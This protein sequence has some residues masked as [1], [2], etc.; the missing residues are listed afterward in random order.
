MRMYGRGPASARDW[1]RPLQ[2]LMFSSFCSGAARVDC[3]RAHQGAGGTQN[4]QIV[5]DGTGSL[6]QPFLKLI[7]GGDD[8][9]QPG[10]VRVK[11]IDEQA[12]YRRARCSSRSLTG[13]P[14]GPAYRPA[15]SAVIATSSF[16]VS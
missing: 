13:D 12:P 16:I 14:R 11:M 10:I 7:G 4:R 2:A 3:A 1:R 6:S 5:A 15:I 8:R 9:R